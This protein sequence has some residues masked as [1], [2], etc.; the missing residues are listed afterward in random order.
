ML[1]GRFLLIV[2]LLGMWGQVAARVS[3]EAPVALAPAQHAL[4]T[5]T[6]A[7]CEEFVALGGEHRCECPAMPQNV[8]SAVSDS[9]KSLI[10]SQVEG[11][12]AFPNSPNPDSVAHVM[13]ARASSFIARHA[14]QPPYRP[15]SRL[16]Q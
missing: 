2:F 12:A 1:M 9:N 8:Q 3:A 11:A 7:V 6:P 10:A 4:P 13:H 14:G 16:R 5:A 15:A